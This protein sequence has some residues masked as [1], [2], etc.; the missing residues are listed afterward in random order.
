[1]GSLSAAHPLGQLEV[2]LRTG[3]ATTTSGD[4]RIGDVIDSSP[5]EPSEEVLLDACLV[6]VADRVTLGQ[7]VRETITS[8][9][10][11]DLT[12][13]EDLVSVF[14]RGIN[15]PGLTRGQLPS[16]NIDIRGGARFW[17]REDQNCHNPRRGH[18][19]RRRG[20]ELGC[21]CGLDGYGWR[22]RGHKLDALPCR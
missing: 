18:D 12:G 16:L 11:R 4:P 8:A 5:A 6:R 2:L 3:I 20:L 21:S 10:A 15:P 19:F 9:R 22:P 17:G 14:K 7:V 13:L 1:M